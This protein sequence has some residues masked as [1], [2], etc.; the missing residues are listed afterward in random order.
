[1]TPFNS[2]GDT[3]TDIAL[4][5]TRDVLYV[6]LSRGGFGG[7]VGIIPNIST[8]TTTASIS[9]EIAVN[10]ITPSITV[11]GPRNVLYVSGLQAAQVLVFDSASAR[12]AGAQPN[13][14]ITMPPVTTQYRLFVETTNDRLYAS[15]MN[16][17]VIL[18]SASTATTSVG[19]AV[20]QLSTMNS[21][22]TA[23][24]ARP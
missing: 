5:A 8:Q 17:V 19:A 12:L 7:T 22:L 15:G 11:D 4:D 1:V 16:R 2:A 9:A 10:A 14:T 6:G 3:L 24:V 18:N 13:R 21:D 23:V 20:A